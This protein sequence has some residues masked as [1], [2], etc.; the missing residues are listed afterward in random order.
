MS[1]CDLVLLNRD[2]A[3]ESHSVFV[4]D[5]KCGTAYETRRYLV[6]CLGGRSTFKFTYAVTLLLLPTVYMLFITPA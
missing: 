3:R 6:W 5:I 4:T 1:I 2:L